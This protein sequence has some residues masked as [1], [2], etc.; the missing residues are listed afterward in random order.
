MDLQVMVVRLLQ[1]KLK[2]LQVLHPIISET[3]SLLNQGM[4]KGLELYLLRVHWLLLFRELERVMFVIQQMTHLQLIPQYQV[5]QIINGIKILQQLP[6]P[7]M[8]CILILL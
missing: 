3:S 2:L 7:L 4:T 6:E 8:L 5:A 1:P